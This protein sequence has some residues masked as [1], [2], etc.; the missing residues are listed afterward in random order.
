MVE[1]VLG[2]SAC[3]QVY[4]VEVQP[5]V[6]LTGGALEVVPSPGGCRG[7]CSRPG[8]GRRGSALVVVP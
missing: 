4:V 3:L 7:T 2:C 1:V 5:Q 8:G 6:A